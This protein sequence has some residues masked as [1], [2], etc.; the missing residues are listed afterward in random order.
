MLETK[1]QYWLSLLIDLRMQYSH[2]IRIL[3]TNWY[4]R[5]CKK[6]LIAYRFPVVR[7]DVMENVSCQLN[8]SKSL[9]VKAIVR[10]TRRYSK[11][12]LY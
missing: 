9:N 7:F 6:S 11:T 4:N 10:F 5:F 8:Y 12:R 2:Y 3:E 1:W